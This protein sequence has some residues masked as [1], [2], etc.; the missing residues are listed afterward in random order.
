MVVRC[1]GVVVVAYGVSGEKG[2]L[3]HWGIVGYGPW[4]FNLGASFWGEGSPMSV[5]SGRL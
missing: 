2:P 3:R 4:G 1:R 5:V